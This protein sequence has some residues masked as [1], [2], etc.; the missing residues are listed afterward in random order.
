MK[1]LSLNGHPDQAHNI[2]F[3]L[4]VEAIKLLEDDPQQYVW[5]RENTNGSTLNAQELGTME[6]TLVQHGIWGQTNIV[7]M[8]DGAC[9]CCSCTP[10][11]CCAVS[12][13]D[14]ESA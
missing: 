4:A 6:D 5:L 3:F 8:A 11:C 10:C 12:I 13:I 9:C 14:Q 1:R 7:L 2:D